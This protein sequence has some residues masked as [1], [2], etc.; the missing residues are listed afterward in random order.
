LQLRVGDPPSLP[1]VAFG[2]NITQNGTPKPSFFIEFSIE[3]RAPECRTRAGTKKPDA[4]EDQDSGKRGKQKGK[5]A[6]IGLKRQLQSTFTT[7]PSI[8]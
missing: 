4:L 3:I 5:K 1:Q 2:V 8:S 7:K 6:S